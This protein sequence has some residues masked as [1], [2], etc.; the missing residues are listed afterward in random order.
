MRSA[1]QL[2]QSMGRNNEVLRNRRAS[3]VEPRDMN[4]ITRRPMNAADG[5]EL[6]EGSLLRCN[7]P[8]TRS[9]PSIFACHEDKK[10]V[11]ENINTDIPKNNIY[12]SPP[13]S[14]SSLHKTKTWKHVGTQTDLPINVPVAVLEAFVLAHRSRVLQLLGVPDPLDLPQEEYPANIEEPSNNHSLF[15]KS[16]C[17]NDDCN[18]SPS[19]VF[20]FR[21]Q[22]KSDKSVDSSSLSS[23]HSTPDYMPIKSI[24][25]AS[26]SSDS[27]SSHSN[28]TSKSSFDNAIQF[29]DPSHIPDKSFVSPSINILNV[30]SS[31]SEADSHYSSSK[32]EDQSQSNFYKNESRKGSCS[33]SDSTNIEEGGKNNNNNNSNTNYPKNQ[34]HDSGIL[35]GTY[36][37]AD[38]QT[39]NPK[40]LRNNIHPNLASSL[41]TGSIREKTKHRCSHN[42]AQ[43]SNTLHIKIKEN[44][45]KTEREN[46]PNISLENHN[47]CSLDCNS[48][49]IICFSEI[50][51]ISRGICRSTSMPA[52]TLKIPQLAPSIFLKDISLPPNLDTTQLNKK[53][54]Q[55][56]IGV[57]SMCVTDF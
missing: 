43:P 14:P 27:L 37:L 2:L 3:N 22:N 57:K 26:N 36:Q 15:I 30:R 24:L 7:I 45:S 33:Q 20:S 23:A 16:N 48:T 55:E 4:N 6:G 18:H 38:L 52:S 25:P 50:D 1:L 29:E 34:R 12:T 49:N 17:K 10:S 9:S 41:S 8:L 51:H 11:G 5:D 31:I 13:S 40:P 28:P 47:C 19:D 21:V 53:E 44:E 56:S 32:E 39:W 35:A 46:S 42:S 54:N